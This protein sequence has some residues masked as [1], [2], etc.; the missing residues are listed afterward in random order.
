M[1]FWIY[2]EQLAFV[3]SWAV[4]EAAYKALYPTCRPSWKD[5]TYRSLIE[6]R[7]PDKPKLLYT[8]S[9][10]DESFK[11]GTLHVSVSHD[12]EYVFTTVLAE[13]P[14]GGIP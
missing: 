5:L 2:I 12:G 1:T 13:V 8:P 6:G 10:R 4:K 11:E 3:I 7:D 9:R 14:I